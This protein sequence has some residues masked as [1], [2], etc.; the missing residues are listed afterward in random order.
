MDHRNPTQRP[1]ALRRLDVAADLGLGHAGI[2]LE[3]KAGDR[4]AV[5]VTAANAGEGD[6]R[7]DVGVPKRERARLSDGV[8]QLLLQADGRRHITRSLT[9]LVIR[10]SWAGRRRSRVLPQ[11][12][13]RR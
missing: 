3:R 11:S 4:L 13:R 10:Q 8:E 2:M 9:P 12:S 1:A 7:A 6:D 5:L